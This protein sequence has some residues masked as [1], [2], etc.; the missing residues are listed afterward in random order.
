MFI[1]RSKANGAILSNY[2][3]TVRDVVMVMSFLK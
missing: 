3:L 1:G 2:F